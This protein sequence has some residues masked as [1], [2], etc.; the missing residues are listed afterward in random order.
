MNLLDAPDSLSFLCPL[1]VYILH[2]AL[3][4]LFQLKLK[5]LSSFFLPCSLFES[6][7]ASL[8]QDFASYSITTTHK[9][10]L[11]IFSTYISTFQLFSS[12]TMPLI[13]LSLCWTVAFVV[14]ACKN[15]KITTRC[16]QAPFSVLTCS[17][18][19]LWKRLK[20]TVGFSMLIKIH[21][22]F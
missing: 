17:Y 9:Q 3:N 15:K 20:I 2:H 8:F 1:A 22:F 16:N 19:T 5:L 12:F 11:S 18:C 13:H 21:Y 7:Q 4:I 10:D 14:C 6:F